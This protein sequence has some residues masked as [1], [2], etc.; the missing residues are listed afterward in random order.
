LLEGSVRRAGERLRIAAQLVD[1]TSGAHLW[2]DKFEGVVKDIFDVQDRITESVVLVVEPH[3]RQAEIERSRRKPPESLDAYDLY[4]RALSKIYV[5]QQGE[6]AEAHALLMRAVE[7]EP[8]Y[9]SFL[10]H[11]GWA[12]ERNVIM[13]W[14]PLTGDD[15]TASLELVR[16]AI[17]NARGDAEVLARC[18]G[19]LLHMEH[20]YERGMQIVA[21][22]VET[23]PNNQMVLIFAAVAQLHCGS[24]EESVAFSRRA[25]MISPGDPAYMP[26][27]AIAHAQMALGNYDEALKA[28]ER[29]RAVNPNYP[30][31]YWMLISANAQLGR[32]DEARRWLAKFRS[33]TPGATIA[34]IWSGQPQKDPSR[35]AAILDGLRLAGLD[36]G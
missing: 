7:L 20:D 22:A 3:I 29:S 18:G 1:G 31:T 6:N 33:L 9:A 36:E 11:A 30:P 4:L 5:S 17:A 25:I 23:N 19:A 35:M 14:P 24:L 8:N 16:R 13:G 10:V 21:S 34:S 32:M 12:L 27:T 15:R 28:A 2:A 26:M